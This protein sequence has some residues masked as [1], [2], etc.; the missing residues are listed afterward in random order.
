[1]E[2]DTEISGSILLINWR[3]EHGRISIALRVV[4]GPEGKHCAQET[5]KLVTTLGFEPWNDPEPVPNMEDRRGSTMER[6]R[7]R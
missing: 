5:Q 1:M 2:A 3:Q 7:G 4:R 6:Q